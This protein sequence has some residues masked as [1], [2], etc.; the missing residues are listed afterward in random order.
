MLPLIKLTIFFYVNALIM[1]M[2]MPEQL[3]IL[4]NHNFNITHGT[5]HKLRCFGK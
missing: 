1:L 4:R 5:T 3:D 2:S